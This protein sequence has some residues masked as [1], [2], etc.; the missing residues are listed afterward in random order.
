[1][2]WHLEIPL[3]DVLFFCSRMSGILKFEMIK[4]GHRVL[5]LSRF[6]LITDR[7]ETERRKPSKQ[8]V[9]TLASA[10]NTSAETCIASTALDLIFDVSTLDELLAAI[11]DIRSPPGLTSFNSLQY[12]WWR[13]FKH[14]Q[15]K[16]QRSWLSFTHIALWYFHEFVRRKIIPWRPQCS[17]QLQHSS[18]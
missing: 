10:S 2:T 14:R 13:H 8:T 6:C 1:M 12:P 16:R 3:N 4:Y 11:M 9:C 18:N 15:R 17:F 7:N 5:H